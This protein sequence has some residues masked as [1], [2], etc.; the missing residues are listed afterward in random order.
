[1]IT[2]ISS[3]C[4]PARTAAS[5]ACPGNG[6]RSGAA[7]LAAEQRCGLRSTA[8]ADRTAAHCPARAENEK[9]ARRGLDEAA[10]ITLRRQ[11]T[12]AA[13]AGSQGEFFHRL[14]Q[15]GLLVRKGFSTQNPARSPGTRSRSPATPPQTAA[16]SGTAAG[17]SQQT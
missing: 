3:R 12:T 2:F 8:P 6:T 5:P 4:W 1:M 11:V 10:R 9:A 14:D 7:R 16:L 17:N 13:A 15:A